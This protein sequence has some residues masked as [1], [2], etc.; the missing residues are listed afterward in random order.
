MNKLILLIALICLT[1]SCGKT[2]AD[3]FQTLLG[4]EKS[5]FIERAN[6][7]FNNFLEHNFDGNSDFERTIN[8]LTYLDTV[9]HPKTDW[10]LDLKT[11]QELLINYE[12]S[13]FRQDFMLYNHETYDTVI[14]LSS[15][16]NSW[17]SVPV[18]DTHSL[19]M[20][21]VEEFSFVDNVDSLAKARAL[22]RSDSS[23][24]YNTFGR[25]H[26]ALKKYYTTDSTVYQ[27]V[28]AKESFP[29]MS[30]AILVA[31]LKENLLKQHYLTD[32]DRLILLCEFY[33]PFLQIQVQENSFA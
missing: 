3:S 11:A 5:L 33:L 18:T 32:G 27:Y 4:S 6:K 1:L 9:Q 17:D 24:E 2:E 31:G 30:H 16:M 25:Y 19:E 22:E 23:L 14:Y 20:N 7:H 21:F 12:H 28:K 8:F 15:S 13:K 10:K 29:R 26:Y